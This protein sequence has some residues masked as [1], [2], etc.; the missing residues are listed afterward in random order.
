MERCNHQNVKHC[1][2]F[3][4][5]TMGLHTQGMKCPWLDTKEW[6]K[7]ANGN[8]TYLQTNFDEAA[9]RKLRSGKTNQKYLDLAFLKKLRAAFSD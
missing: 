9:W 6:Y 1:K 2:N 5:L 4:D 8:R 7:Y 3:A